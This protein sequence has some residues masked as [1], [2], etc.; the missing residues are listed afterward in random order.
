MNAQKL[1]SLRPPREFP[2]LNRLTRLYCWMS[3]IGAVVLAMG[4]GLAAVWHAW[5]YAIPVLS[6]GTIGLVGGLWGRYRVLRLIDRLR[7]RRLA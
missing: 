1:A 7:S 5:V 2:A 6:G 3:A 4:F